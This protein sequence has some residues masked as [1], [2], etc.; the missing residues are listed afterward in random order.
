MEMGNRQMKKSG[1]VDF[2]EIA[3]NVFAALTPYK[4]LSWANAG[5]INKGKGLVV[6][7][8]AAL[9]QAQELKDF[10]TKT[11]R[12]TPG[13]VVNTHP[14]MDHLNGNQL[15]TDSDIIAHQNF[16]DEYD[17]DRF[18]YWQMVQKTGKQSGKTGLMFLAK[19]I[20]GLDF[21]GI[22]PVAPNI[23]FDKE[24]VI[25]LE[26][27]RVELK[28]IGPAHTKSDVLVWLPKEKVLFAGDVIF[29][30]V[31]GW[32]EQGVKGWV[33]ALDYIYRELKPQVVVPGHGSICDAKVVADMRDYF[34]N[35]IDTVDKYYDE[36]ITALELAKK[37][38]I[39]DYLHWFQPERLF[40][41]VSTIVKGRRGQT[42]IKDWEYLAPNMAEL[43]G[44]YDKL[45]GRKTT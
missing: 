20:E 1:E 12:K 21:S 22:T 28:N 26:D 14:D 6:D 15:F 39:R 44:Y 38:D 32:S 4:G 7:T 11:H 31:V 13:Y 24:M 40:V 27:M 37:I 10:V 17:A 45:Y 29:D 16:F 33:G 2:V 43:K 42:G 41:T 3:D 9:S 30:G 19:N 23:T 34:Q 35:I 18:K 8:L 5:F 25:Q 36:D